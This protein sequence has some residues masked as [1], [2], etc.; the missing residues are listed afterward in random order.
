LGKRLKAVG[1]IPKCDDGALNIKFILLANILG[2]VIK[3][4]TQYIH[5]T[6]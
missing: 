2:F 6:F 3:N 5:W 1:G 4:L